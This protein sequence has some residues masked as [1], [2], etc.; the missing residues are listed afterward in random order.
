MFGSS[1]KRKRTAV[2]STLKSALSRHRRATA[3]RATEGE[4][5]SCDYAAWILAVL[6]TIFVIV[7]HLLPGVIAGLLVYELVHVLFPVLA[8]RLPDKRAKF[9]AV[10]LIA[11]LVVGAIT[12]AAIGII[13]FMRSEGGSV[14]ALLAKM[15]EILDGSRAAL[16]PSFAEYLPSDAGEMREAMTRWLREHSVDVQQVGRRTGVMLVHVIVGMAI[17]AM[18]AMREAFDH[19]AGGPLTRALA[20]RVYRMGEAFRRVVFA[21]VKI[22]AINTIFT[23]IYLTVVLP[24]LGIHLPLTKTMIAVTFIA[25]LLPVIGNL[26]SNT[27]I[28]VVSLAHSPVVAASSLVYLIVIHKLE[29]FLNARIVGVKISAKAWELL[30]AMLLME[31]IFGLAG[32]VAAPICYAWLK[33]ELATRK[34]I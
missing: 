15:A 9:A 6:G 17:G 22:S 29:Y 13:G 11:L 3:P 14:A 33:D 16:P 7:C 31:S 25:G 34:L 30:I 23:A 2:D 12:A 28:V 32:L 24:L 26:I 10:A 8:R 4:C 18:I 21:Q 20:E 1:P 5:T 19:D 27:M